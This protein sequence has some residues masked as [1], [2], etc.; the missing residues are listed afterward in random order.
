MDFVDLKGASGTAYRFRRWPMAGA[1]PPIAGN[2]ALLAA[3]TH[4]LIEVG[5]LDDLSQAPRLLADRVQRGALYT[6]FNVA[7][8]YREADHDDLARGHPDLG[9]AAEHAA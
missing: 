8:A 6:R 7:R 1:H 9:Q 3:G 4:R 2:Y 5:V